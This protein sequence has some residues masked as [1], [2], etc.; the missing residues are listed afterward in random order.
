M[1]VEALDS[2]REVVADLRP[3]NTVTNLRE[4]LQAFVECINVADTAVQVVV[5][6]DEQWIPQSLHGQLF[7]IIRESL[8]NVFSHARA[9]R[10]VVWVD[11]APHEVRACVEDEG[12]GFDPDAEMAKG[13]HGLSSMRERT[14][15]LGGQIVISSKRSQGTSV[16][17]LIPFPED[18]T[19]FPGGNSH[20]DTS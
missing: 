1:L 13:S 11:I 4:S 18:S 20:D 9:K 7:L 17:V 3:S 15:L 6:G 10:V 8:R 16:E 5:T 12:I 14:E 2:I 19:S